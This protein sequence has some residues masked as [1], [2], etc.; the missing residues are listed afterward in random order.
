MVRRCLQPAYHPHRCLTPC[1]SR[2]GLGLGG[3]AI[4][5]GAVAG[6]LGLCGWVGL[7]G[8]L[9]IME[10]IPFLALAGQALL[11]GTL[12]PARLDPIAAC[13]LCTNPIPAPTIPS[14]R[15]QSDDHC[16]CN[17]AAAALDLWPSRV[18]WCGSCHPRPRWPSAGS[19]RTLHHLGCFLRG[20]VTTLNSYV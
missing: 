17:A 5:G 16:T 20:C 11:C 13:L 10:V 6:A 3:V 18:L 4:V 2:A 14:G 8:T 12:P 7:K 9:I 1:H 19:G 15:G